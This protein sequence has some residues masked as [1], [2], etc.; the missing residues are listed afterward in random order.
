MK[1]PR[2]YK[3]AFPPEFAGE[4]IGILTTLGVEVKH[5]EPVTENVCALTIDLDLALARRFQKW[6]RGITNREGT[7]SP[8]V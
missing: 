8:G 1:Q 7:M 4:V 3:V 2:E 5:F 6:L